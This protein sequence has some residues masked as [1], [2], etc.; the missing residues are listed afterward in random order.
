MQRAEHRTGANAHD[1]PMKCG[2]HFLRCGASSWLNAIHFDCVNFV[3]SSSSPCP[4]RP[5]ASPHHRCTD[6]IR[7]RS[8]NLCIVQNKKLQDA[9]MGIRCAG[10]HFARS[11]A[12]D[13]QTHFAAFLPGCAHSPA[14]DGHRECNERMR[15]RK[16]INNE[17]IFTPAKSH[18]VNVL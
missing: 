8:N 10:K 14:H 2:R 1:P 7:V 16:A 13:T 3:S 11:S 18:S 4:A 15:P 6:P 12:L 5:M 9:P 17:P